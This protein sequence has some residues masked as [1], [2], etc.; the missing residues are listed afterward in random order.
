MDTCAIE[1]RNTATAEYFPYRRGWIVQ[2]RTGSRKENA[3][4]DYRY[5]M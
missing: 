4:K 5:R 2:T 3:W 1:M